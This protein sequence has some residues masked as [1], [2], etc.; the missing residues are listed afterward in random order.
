MTVFFC[1]D[2]K[3]LDL[4]SLAID[5]KK[6]MQGAWVKMGA[7]EFL[8][9][10]YNNPSATAA[11]SAAV[12]SFYSEIKDQDIL[13]DKVSEKYR[14]LNVEVFAKE[15]LLD[16]KGVGLPTGKKT[17]TGEVELEA[18]DYSVEKGIAFLSNMDYYELYQFLLEKSI[19]HD[20]YQKENEEAVVED[21]KPTANS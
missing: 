3:L 13:D 18:V 8:L 1:K 12:A 15:V 14:I 21:V 7:A 20:R 2:S 10:R 11:R 19:E 5:S 16:W 9:A 6:A 4:T 17:K